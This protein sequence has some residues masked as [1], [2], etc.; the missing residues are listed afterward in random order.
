MRKPTNPKE[1]AGSNKPPLH[2]VPP[3]A[4]AWQSLA[5]LWGALK[6]GRTNWRVAGVRTSIYVDAA[7]RHL[8]A[9]SEGEDLDADSGLPHE[10]MVAA[11]M[12]ILLD[13][14]AAGKLVDDRAYPGG[15][16]LA[17][18][19]LVPHVARMKAS[20]EAAG[21]KP[22]HF[23]IADYARGMPFLGENVV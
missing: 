11:C 8:D 14:R 22:K 23:T 16:R 13:A 17:F 1:M 7:K 18:D 15:Y 3:I 2:L 5:H 9:M 4:V 21:Y 12:N 20:A 19:A 10:A 6:Y